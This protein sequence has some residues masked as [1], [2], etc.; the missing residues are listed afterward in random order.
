[1]A[2]AES[3]Q[4]SVVMYGTAYCP[5][6]VRARR[7]LDSKGVEYEDIRLEGRPDLRA[8]MEQR[9]GGGRTVPQIFINEEHIGG[10][11]DLFALERAGRLDELLQR[12]VTETRGQCNE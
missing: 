9:S 6:C 12:G 3:P 4:A 1:M 2:R 11:D 8:E 7:L 5:Y 10:S